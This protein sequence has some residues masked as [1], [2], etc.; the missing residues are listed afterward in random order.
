M[1][2]S[3]F[4]Y[5]T[6]A[7]D[8]SRSLT[9]DEVDSRKGALQ[10]LRDSSS[11]RASELLAELFSEIYPDQEAPAVP[12]EAWRLLGFQQ[13]NPLSDLRASGVSSLAFMTWY[14]KS[15]HR[16]EGLRI[17]I[18]QQRRLEKDRPDAN[19]YFPFAIVCTSLL[20]FILS[21]YKLVD[22]YNRVNDTSL[23]TQ[24]SNVFSTD[25]AFENTARLL[26]VFYS[27]W[28]ELNASYMDFPK[29]FEEAKR[30]FGALQ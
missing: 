10:L 28:K 8:S 13:D 6:S 7:F 23:W 4:T 15:S 26:S 18:E 22:K 29:V 9:A 27:T 5:I 1:I 12:S 17:L 24:S 16:D 30:R 11:S 25:D 21:E 19:N 20:L 3:L 14:F 2:S